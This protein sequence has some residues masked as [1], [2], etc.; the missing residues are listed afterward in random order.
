[1]KKGVIEMQILKEVRKMDVVIDNPI[2]PKKFF[3]N[4]KGLYVWSGFTEKIIER[5]K[6]TKIEKGSHAI[7]SLD[8]VT[9]ATDEQIELSL[10]NKN[11][12]SE[13]DAAALIAEM[14]ARQPNGEDGELLTSGDV[15]LFYTPACVVYVLWRAGGGEW[16]VF[17][18]DRDDNW[19]RAGRR[20]FSPQ[21][22][23]DL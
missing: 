7:E 23:L 11:V 1:M 21:L 10:D 18:W 9:S 19:W 16:R 4:R 20:V 12:F 15:N 17:A 8:L 3:V 13:S 14:I 22:A 5:G 6:A 2:E